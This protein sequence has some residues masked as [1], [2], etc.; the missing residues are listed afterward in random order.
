VI[1]IYKHCAK[2]LKK[3]GD[4]VKAG[5]IIAFVGNSGNLSNGTH[6]HFELWVNGIPVDAE[7][8]I[9]F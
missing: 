9:I 2:L 8:Y 1:S 5:E 6:L 7:R 4:T 3:S